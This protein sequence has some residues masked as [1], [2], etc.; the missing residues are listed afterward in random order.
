MGSPVADVHDDRRGPRSPGISR[1][2]TLRFYSSITDDDDAKS[3]RSPPRI[4]TPG[5]ISVPASP[6]NACPSPTATNASASPRSIISAAI[7]DEVEAEVESRRHS[8]GSRGIFSAKSP[9]ALHGKTFQSSTRLAKTMSASRVASLLKGFPFFK[10]FEEGLVARLSDLVEQATYP[11]GTVLFCQD[12]PPGN[13]YVI[14]SGQVSVHI[15]DERDDDDAETRVGRRLSDTGTYTAARRPSFSRSSTRRSLSNPALDEHVL[16]HVA[17]RHPTVEG[18]SFYHAGTD[19][20]PCVKTIEAGNIVGELALLNDQPRSGS[21][22]CTRETSFIIIGRVEFENVL[23]AEMQRTREEK[24]NFLLDH[25]PG[26]RDVPVARPGGRP[27]P[28]Y[29]FKKVSVSKGHEFLKQGQIAEDAVHVVFK[30]VV[31]LRRCEPRRQNSRSGNISTEMRKKTFQKA[32]GRSAL[33]GLSGAS[34]PVDDLKLQITRQIGTLEVGGV[35]GS[36]P[37]TEAEPFTV[38]ARSAVEVFSIAQDIPRLPL[39]LLEVIQEYLTQAT[40]WRLERLPACRS[41]DILQQ[42]RFVYKA[43]PKPWIGNGNDLGLDLLL[44]GKLHPPP[45]FGQDAPHPG[46]PT[47]GTIRSASQPILGAS[48]PGQRPQSAPLGGRAAKERSSKGDAVIGMQAS[49]KRPA[50][51]PCIA[52]QIQSK[53]NAQKFNGVHELANRK[54]KTSDGRASAHVKRPVSAHTVGGKF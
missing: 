22:K 45:S 23:K 3:P 37:L 44:S 8:S 39:K 33:P 30:G 10:D 42:Q 21:L 14:V 49:T 50:S 32:S 5:S 28:T 26:L 41:S 43:Q 12:D 35:F 34:R 11:A 4:N 18:F 17:Q 31:E 9:K 19:L 7:A 6:I 38:V 2:S 27:H 53:G 36:L 15:R 25:L 24:V 20:G 51:A 46:L 40:T 29:Y 13:C 1:Q 47:R 16:E 48:P 52:S 54:G